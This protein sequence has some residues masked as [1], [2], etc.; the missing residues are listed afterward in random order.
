MK[1]TTCA[2]CGGTVVQKPR[3]RH[4]KYCGQLCKRATRRAPRALPA[5]LPSTAVFDS[6]DGLG[7]WTVRP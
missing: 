1:T 5:F 7:R 6:R 3:G 4:A 2:T